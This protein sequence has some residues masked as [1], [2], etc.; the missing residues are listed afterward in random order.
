MNF[1]LYK[2]S[3]FNKPITDRLGLGLDPGLEPYIERI[4]QNPDVATTGSCSGHD[5]HPYVQLIFRNSFVA[6]KYVSELRAAGYRVTIVA[7]GEYYVDIPYTATSRQME[8]LYWTPE[9]ENEHLA[10]LGEYFNEEESRRIFKNQLAEA[11]NSRLATPQESR[12]FWQTITE[13]LSE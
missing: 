3:L 12:K 2:A 5:G 9:Q 1:D 11:R 7:Q 8:M 13:I 6:G 4:N 10:D